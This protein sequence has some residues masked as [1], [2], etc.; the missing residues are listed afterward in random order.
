MA[1]NLFGN[2]G[3]RT[4][5]NF[6]VWL[7]NSIHYFGDKSDAFFSEE[8]RVTNDHIEGLGE[9]GE[10]VR[11][12]GLFVVERLEIGSETG[13]AFIELEEPHRAVRMDRFDRLVE[14]R[15]AQQ[16]YPNVTGSLIHVVD[17]SQAD[18]CQSVLCGFVVPKLAQLL[19]AK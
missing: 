3:A 11:L 7:S 12:R 5:D 18:L 16:S 15:T 19:Q 2:G 13:K 1:A 4:E 6:C 10:V 8:R 14:R 17:E 9:F